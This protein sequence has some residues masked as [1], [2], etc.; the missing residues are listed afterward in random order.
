MKCSKFLRAGV[1]SYSIE[2]LL[3]VQLCID[4]GLYKVYK[5]FVD[6]WQGVAVLAGQGVK[7]VVIYTEVESPIRL[8]HE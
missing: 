4:L 6:K 3:Y 7:L 1:Y 8:L 5:R 2:G